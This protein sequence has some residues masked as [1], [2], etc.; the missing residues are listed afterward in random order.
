LLETCQIEAKIKLVKLRLALLQEQRLTGQELT[1]HEKQLTALGQKLTLL[2]QQTM[3]T[4][5]HC[6]K[7]PQI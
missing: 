6:G 7:D 4:C 1:A 5:I 3:H 2:E